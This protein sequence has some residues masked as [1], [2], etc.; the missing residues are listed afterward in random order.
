MQNSVD[1][2]LFVFVS[3]IVIAFKKGGRMKVRIK[4]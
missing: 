3:R 1:M 2:S 4:Y